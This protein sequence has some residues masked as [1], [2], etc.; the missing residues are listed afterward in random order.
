M[1]SHGVNLVVEKG[2]PPSTEASELL[3]HEMSACDQDWA[4]F[5]SPSVHCS[6]HEIYIYNIYGLPM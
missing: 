3:M 5:K 2:P 4:K 1:N 6:I